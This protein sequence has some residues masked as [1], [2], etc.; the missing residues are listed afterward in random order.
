M[1]PTGCLVAGAAHAQADASAYPNKP[2]RLIVG[3]TPGRSKWGQI[4]FIISSTFLCRRLVLNDIET[5]LMERGL[6]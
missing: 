5:L 6:N 3:F 1:K 4:P 2:V